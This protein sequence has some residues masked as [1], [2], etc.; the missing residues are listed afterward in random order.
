MELSTDENSWSH[1]QIFLPSGP[2][3]NGSMWVENPICAACEI[4]TISQ[5]ELGSD[6]SSTE[7]GSVNGFS[8]TEVARSRLR[9]EGVG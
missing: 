3:F 5:S 7:G 2:V 4:T 9:P 8:T 1:L 6:S